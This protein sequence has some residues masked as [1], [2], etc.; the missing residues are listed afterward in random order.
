MKSQSFKLFA[1]AFV[2]GLVTI[3]AAGSANAQEKLSFE[4]SFDFHV[5][6]DKLSAGTYELQM[7]SY[8]RYALR[9]KETKEARIVLFD[10]ATKNTDSTV[11]ERIVFNR[12]GETYFLNGIFDRRDADGKQI[13][14]SSYEKQVRKNGASRENQLAGEKM[15]PTKVSVNLSR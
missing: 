2:L 1:M 5:G 14:A 11:S 8:G 12:Y 13:V 10:I 3:F 7:M 9:N 15:K 6:K 4:T